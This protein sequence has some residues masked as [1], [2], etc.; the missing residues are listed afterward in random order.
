MSISNWTS[1]THTYEILK[2]K[3]MDV[4]G[5]YVYVYFLMINY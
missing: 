3:N 2:L 5:C 4:D 1:A